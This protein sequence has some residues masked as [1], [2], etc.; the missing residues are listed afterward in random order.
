MYNK[1]CPI[2]KKMR[3]SGG[4]LYTFSSALEDIGLNI[5]ERNNIVKLSNYALLNI[6]TTSYISESTANNFNFTNILGNFNYLRSEIGTSSVITPNDAI[7]QSFQNYALNFETCLLDDTQYN[8]AEQL[9]VSERVF[10]KWLKESGAIRFTKDNKGNIIEELSTS[11]NS[12]NTV[13]NAIGEI[14]AGSFNSDNIG[15]FNETYIQ[16]PSSFGKTNVFFNEVEDINYAYNKIINGGSK[17][18]KGRNSSSTDN[19]NITGYYDYLG[20]NLIN[21]NYK[22][23]YSTDGTTWHDG[24]WYNAYNYV[25]DLN[26]DPSVDA[27]SYI[28]DN[29]EDLTYNENTLLRYVDQNDNEII[30]PFLRSNYDCISINFDINKDMYPASPY[31]VYDFNELA[32]SKSISNKYEFNAVLVYYKVYN[33]S[34][35]IVLATNLLG[36]L[37]IDSPKGVIS[38]ITDDIT[39]V[40]TYTS[41]IYIPTFEKIKSSADG[42]GT[43]A[44]LRISI[45]SSNMIDD[46]DATI[47]DKTNSVSDVNSF[48]EI[49][50][51]LQK[52]LNILNSNS[53]MLTTVSDKYGTL[54]SELSNTKNT[55]ETL[56]FKLNN[57]IEDLTENSNY[58]KVK[59]GTLHGELVIDK[60][61]TSLSAL[62]NI[63]LGVTYKG[64]EISKETGNLCKNNKLFL[65]S[66][67]SNIRLGENLEVFDINNKNTVFIGNNLYNEEN[68]LLQTTNNENVILIGSDISF[69][70]DK[71]NN[72]SNNIIIGNKLHSE[73]QKNMLMLGNKT[74][75]LTADLDDNKTL[76][77]KSKRFNLEGLVK[78][79]PSDTTNVGSGTGVVVDANGDI[80][81]AAS[82]RRFKN[83]IKPLFDTSHVLDLNPVTYTYKINDDIECIGLIAEEVAEVD[84]RLVNYD[85]NNKPLSVNYELISVLLINEIK[86]LKQEI[87]VLKNK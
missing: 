63:N 61:N 84:K 72:L 45:Q 23:Q 11:D 48:S 58:L 42:F 37:F 54:S 1:K 81:M 73:S 15:T 3:T 82:S 46:T 52:S 20:N 43:S 87:E 71:D 67:E 57:L 83:N 86:K 27:F 5:N 39:N 25:N 62:G 8:P 59:G 35:D 44:S 24:W 60:R 22:P 66:L 41:S 7:A 78:T 68:E 14:S 33:Q 34:G 4:T 13:V 12:Y 30:Q 47:I 26:L 36:V 79:D 2:I 49:F 51:H 75:I 55:V 77:I 17:F 6:P 70:Q 38:E 9:T 69:A 74:P 32:T 80:L 50:Q 19:W 56:S 85:K 29:K 65:T 16:V 40:T 10:W 21:I 18:I 28:T 76:S 53:K 31:D 64:E